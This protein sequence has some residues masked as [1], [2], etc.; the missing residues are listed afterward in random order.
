MMTKAP[1]TAVYDTLSLLFDFPNQEQRLW[2]HSIAPMFAAMLD[3]A[4]HNVHDQYRHLGIFKKHIIPFLGVYPAQGKHTWPSVLTRYGI[5]FELSLN[6]LDSVVRYT[7]EPTTEHTGTGDDSYNAFAILE[8]IQKLVRIQPGIDMEWF[9]YFRNEL[10]LNATESARLGRNDSVNQQPIR[11]QN[12]LALDLKGDRFALKV[13][14]YPHL[15]SIATGVSSHDL[16]FNSVRKLSQKHTSI[17]PSFNVLCDYVA[18]RNDPDSNAAEAEAGVPASALRARLLSCDLVD[19]SKSRIKIYLLEQTVSLTAMEDLWTLGGRRTDSSTLNGLD[20]MRELWHLLQIPSGFMKYPESDLK[21]GE[22]PDE[23][24]PSMV[25]YALHPDQPMPEPQVYFTVFGMSDA[26]IT[27]AL[28]TFFSR[29]GWY[30]MA[31]KYRVFLEGS[32]PNHDFESLNYLHTYVSFSY[33]KNKPYL[34]VYLH[35]FETGQWPAFSDDPTA[36]NA[37]KR[38]DLSLT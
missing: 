13:Y 29:H 33:R 35:S 6:C 11:T 17:Q 28:A 10:V 9:S 2:W 27:N 19:P 30:E 14:L 21:L 3:T 32:F 15:K 36:F 16:I 8:C 5:P 7:F 18:S 12:K 34:S 22:V 4:G 38:C 24:L 31:K 1:A 20:M 26:G 25:H 23:Q 37:F